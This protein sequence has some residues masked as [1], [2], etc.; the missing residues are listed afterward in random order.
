MKQN[1]FTL[2]PMDDEDEDNL[3]WENMM[4][5]SYEKVEEEL[6]KQEKEEEEEEQRRIEEDNN[7]DK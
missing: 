5:D 6:R 1:R 7:R 3:D 2:G 4:K